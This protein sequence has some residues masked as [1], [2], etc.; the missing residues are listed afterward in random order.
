MRQ[1][2]SNDVA[3][4]N[5]IS[6]V[7][8]ILQVITEST[9]LGFAAVARVTEDSWTACAVLDNLGFGLKPG[10]EL[11]LTSTICHEIRSS[12]KPVVID[13]VAEDELFCAHHT[14]RR[15]NF[16]SYISIPIFLT[17]GSFFG[18]ICALD[19]KPARLTGTPIEAMMVSFARLLA[20]QIEAEENMQRVQADLL[21]EREVAELRDQFIAV[22]GHDLRN[23]LFAINA[24]AELLLRRP[25]DDKTLQVAQHIL[26][27]GQR[28]SQLVDDV[29]DFARGRMGH[30]I[31]LS[32][33]DAHGLDKTLEH[34]VSEIQR[35]HPA[36]LIRSN[37]GALELIR[38]DHERIAQLLSNLVSNAIT[39]GAF[40]SSVEVAA[41]VLGDRFVLSVANQG[42]PI[43]ESMRSQLFLPYS[44]PITNEPQAGLGLGLYIASEIAQAHGGTLDVS[45]T[46]EGGT[47]FT[48]SMPL[49]PSG[50]CPQVNG[51]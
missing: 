50:A 31:P 9:G 32:I 12:H 17:D 22:L 38:C 20:L 13:H 51:V 35:V 24:S 8:A 18:T 21:A 3:T 26:T 28:A 29:L 25:L 42:E 15:Y 41:G 7:P 30:G 11:E 27:S 2:I 4:I 49:R 5:R 39:H 45:S 43:P 33:H 19:P 47:V 48:F 34:V 23:P 37:I 40:D 44:R 1:S 16:Q 10:G 36:R 14:P 46:Q 6:A